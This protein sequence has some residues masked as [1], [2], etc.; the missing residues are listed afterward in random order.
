[1]GFQMSSDYIVPWLELNS[2]IV[3]LGILAAVACALPGNFLVL[4][5]MSMMGDAISHAVL[6]GLVIGFMLTH[7]RSSLKMFIAA[8]IVGVLT[9]LFT[10]LINRY[11]K[12]D[13]SAAMGVV[14]TSLF[15][16]GILLIVKFNDHVDLD[17]ECIL[18]G[19]LENVALEGTALW[20]FDAGAVPLLFNTV[21]LK[22][23]LVLMINIAFIILFFKE[24]KLTSFDPALATT[25]GINAQLMHY[26]LMTVVAVTTVAAFETVGSIMVIAMLIIPPAVAYLLTDK[27]WLMILISAIILYLSRLC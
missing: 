26:L 22:L 20:Q 8:A 19:A 15:A 10:Q 12:V 21:H 27:L 7:S 23:T 14:F 25:I 24:L 16:L 18:Y 6:P 1:M 4:R 5:K 9:A 3:L 2:A 11:G 13:E 17:P